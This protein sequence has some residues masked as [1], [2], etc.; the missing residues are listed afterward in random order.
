MGTVNLFSILSQINSIKTCLVTTTDKVYK[1]AGVNNFFSENDTLG[2][3]EAYSSSKVCVEHYL[4]SISQFLN[5]NTV[6]VR[7]GNVVGLGDFTN[8]RIVPDILKAINT[9]K[10]LMIRNSNAIRPWLHVLDS[11]N[12]YVNLVEK[13]FKNEINVKKFSAWNFGPNKS[14][15]IQVIS[16]VKKFLKHSDLNYSIEK[17]C[18]LKKINI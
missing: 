10:T 13:I 9:K 4:S 16:L 6:S 3:T 12:G 11:I 17:K 2:G 15:H 1:P 14:N 7:S 18:Y 5:F 8:G